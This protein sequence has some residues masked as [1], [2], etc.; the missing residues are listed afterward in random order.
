MKLVLSFILKSFDFFCKHAFLKEDF[1]TVLINKIFKSPLK[2]ITFV[3]YFSLVD[4]ICILHK[5]HH[6][7]H[8]NM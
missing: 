1:N 2:W 6:Y 4:L 3:T 5:S 8:H 7:V